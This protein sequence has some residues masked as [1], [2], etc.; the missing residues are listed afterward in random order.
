MKRGKLAVG[1]DILLSDGERI[2]E[3]DQNAGYKYLG[4]LQADTIKSNEAKEQVRREYLH[5]TRLVL[6]SQLNAGNTVKAINS[7]AVPVMRYTAGV[8]EWTVA[9]LQEIDRKTRKMMTIHRAFNMNGDVDRLYI[10]RKDGG[11][12]LLQIEQ[13]IREEECAVADYMKEAQRDWLIQIATREHVMETV[14]TMTSYRQRVEQQRKMNWRNK[15]LHGQFLRQTECLIDEEESNQWLKDGYMKKETESLLMA[16]QEQSLRT[17]KIMHDIDQRNIDPKCRLCGEKDETAEHL[18]SACPKLAQT[19]YKARHDKVASIVHWHLCKKYGI[20]VEK[21]WYKHQPDSVCENDRTKI[22]WDFSIQT[23]KVIKERRPD[24]VVVDKAQNT[25]MIID[26]AVPADNNIV[27]KQEEKITKYQDLKMEIRRLWKKKGRV[28]PIVVGALGSV[29]KDLKKNLLDMD[30][31]GCECRTLQKAA[32]LG[33]ARIL[34]R[35][36]AL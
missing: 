7:W 14:E 25:V 8:V 35:V 36:M 29:P 11:K 6:Q 30:L 10:K 4:I 24:L 23:D 20:S 22:L 18:V 32:L 9:E 2:R 5:R 21:E 26:I 31:S 12:G 17:R 27:T 13:V 34:R 15:K 3:I 1:G 33:T 28:I 16:A 19:E